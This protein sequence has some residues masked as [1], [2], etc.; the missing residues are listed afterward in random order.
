MFMRVN[1][2]CAH[3]VRPPLKPISG[4]LGRCLAVAT[5]A[6]SQDQPPNRRH[7]TAGAPLRWSE[8]W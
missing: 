8:R 6:R 1:S 5:L 3:Q 7:S 4:E 2:Q